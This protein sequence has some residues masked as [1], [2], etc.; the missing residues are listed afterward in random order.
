MD[1]FF[2]QT[3]DPQQNNKQA[4]TCNPSFSC[5][6]HVD[7]HVEGGTRGEISSGVTAHHSF[8][9]LTKEGCENSIR[10]P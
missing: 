10:I 9:H 8:S 3:H 2:F 5:S 4:V 7:S 1:P 6:L